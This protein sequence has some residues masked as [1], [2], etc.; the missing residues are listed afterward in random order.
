[1]KT[2]FTTNDQRGFTLIEMLVGF[3]LFGTVALFILG[4]VVSIYRSRT[5]SS[6]VEFMQSATAS[7]VQLMTQDVHAATGVTIYQPLADSQL[8]LE[9]RDE[10]G[11]GEVLYTVEEGKI[12]RDA[13]AITPDTVKVTDFAVENVQPND[14][15][16]LL[17]IHFVIESAN[18]D[19]PPVE[20]TLYL[21]F[22]AK[23]EE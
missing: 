18:Y 15:L 23:G 10:K 3:A 14:L 19:I 22:R 2:N 9:F 17:K 11:E 5:A 13:Q 12:M 16:P 20:K 21:S 8:Y 1:M 6:Q 4:I 7:L